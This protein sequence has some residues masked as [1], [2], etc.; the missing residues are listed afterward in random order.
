MNIKKLTAGLCLIFAAWTAGAQIKKVTIVGEVRNLGNKE[1]VLLDADQSELGKAMA[2]NG[3]F[4]ITRKLEI[5]DMRYYT[6]YIPSVG[7]LG[8]SMSIPVINFFICSDKI[9]IRAVIRDKKVELSLIKGSPCGEEYKKLFDSLP[10]SK[11]LEAAIQPYNDAFHQYNDVENTDKNKEK[12]KAIGEKIDKLEG[13]QR[14]QILDL[15]PSHPKNMPVAVMASMYCASSDAVKDLET[16]YNQFDASIR[17]CYYLEQIRKKI[18]RLKSIEIGQT[19]PDFELKDLEGKPVK[20]SSFTGK[21]VLLDFW[22]SWCGPCRAEN[23]NVVKA[24]DTYKTKGFTVLGVSL[25]A[26][27]AAWRK[28]VKEDGMPWRQVLDDKSS[29]GKA[30]SQ[31]EI[32]SIPS[33]F[34]LDPKGKI[35]A[36]DLRG[37][38]L[39]KVLKEFVK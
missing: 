24:F 32:K 1:V 39:Q 8:P 21:Y 15:I 35:I 12:L 36:R 17:N 33:N 14:Q 16:F 29:A 3:R 20:L 13:E 23:P 31:Y 19:A 4:T 25:D 18:N 11:E 5:G 9:N 37:E 22:A 34:L 2:T 28:A 6:L 10:A 26:N 27:E 38:E 7:P 30:Q